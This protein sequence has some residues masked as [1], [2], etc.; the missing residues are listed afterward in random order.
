MLLQKEFHSN[1]AQVKL[2][3]SNYLSFALL[4]NFMVHVL[5]SSHSGIKSTKTWCGHGP[6]SL[7]PQARLMAD[8]NLIVIIICGHS[9]TK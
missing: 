5:T 4:Y 2:A 6:T 1:V 3:R 7:C 8:I 9:I